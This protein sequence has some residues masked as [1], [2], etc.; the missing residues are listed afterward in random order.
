[1][2]QALRPP[3][4]NIKPRHQP[5]LYGEYSPIALEVVQ[6]LKTKDLHKSLEHCRDAN[7]NER[8]AGLCNLLIYMRRGDTSLTENDVILIRNTLKRFFHEH[9][10]KLYRV[11]IEVLHDFIQLK[12]AYLEGWIETVVRRLLGRLGSELLA[13]LQS[14]IKGTLSSLQ[15]C[16][17]PGF[18]FR[19]TARIIS[20]DDGFEPKSKLAALDYFSELLPLLHPE[21]FFDHIDLQNCLFI[22][23]TDL[24]TKNTSMRLKIQDLLYVLFDLNPTTFNKFIT[25]MPSKLEANLTR[26][27][28]RHW[29]KVIENENLSP[30]NTFHTPP[31]EDLRGCVQN[32]KNLR[33]NINLSEILYFPSDSE[34]TSSDEQLSKSFS[35]SSSSK[36]PTDS[37]LTHSLNLYSI[38]QTNEIET[39]PSGF[40]LLQ[41]PP[42]CTPP[43]VTTS[44]PPPP[45]PL[46]DPP[47]LTY[48]SNFDSVSESI[49]ISQNL[50]DSL[51]Y[52]ILP[53]NLDGS[54]NSLSISQTMELSGLTK[55]LRPRSRIPVSINQSPRLSY[56][57][58]SRFSS[59][60]RSLNSSPLDNIK[61][62]LYY[63]P[64]FVKNN[65]S[66]S[67]RP[68]SSYCGSNLISSVLP[69]SRIPRYKSSPSNTLSTPGVYYSNSQMHNKSS[70]RPKEV[71]YETEVMESSRIKLATTPNKVQRRSKVCL[72]FSMERDSS[73][74]SP[75]N[76]VNFG[77]IQSAKIVPKFYENPE[78]N[79][80]SEQ[81]YSNY[82][83]NNNSSSTF[84]D[85]S[86]SNLQST[87][88]PV[89]IPP[90][91]N[92]SCHDIQTVSCTSLEYSEGELHSPAS[93]SL[94][95]LLNSF[96]S[97]QGVEERTNSMN[98]LRENLK[99]YNFVPISTNV[100]L[101]FIPLSTAVRELISF[102]A[103]FTDKA[104][105]SIHTI[106][107]ISQLFPS[108]VVKET[109]PVTKLLIIS[110]GNSSHTTR[111]KLEDLFIILSQSLDISLMLTILTGHLSN[112]TI[113]YLTPLKLLC[114]LIPHTPPHVL[115][116]QVPHFAPDLV[117]AYQQRLG[118]QNA[119]LPCLVGLYN[120]LGSQ[121]DSYLTELSP[122][123]EKLLMMYV[124]SSAKKRE[125]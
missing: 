75:N 97:A 59:K 31:H 55:S 49:P 96:L 101:L 125:F 109:E 32:D 34:E 54:M 94:E 120:S 41:P 39:S 84:I 88:L 33:D 37:K 38:N 36:E 80:S 4:P 65:I 51:S 105:V 22:L 44:P 69:P 64:L 67:N 83:E 91:T 78:L 63:S 2:A 62:R 99:S 47:S 112:V 70:E 116:L 72:D 21:D 45:I 108:I 23:A 11:F 6:K 107:L 90:V 77:I 12:C 10:S 43:P 29:A 53:N 89:I 87:S 8:R 13:S 85:S 42:S 79:L 26:S 27:I 1:M 92:H 95:V 9:N 18:L 122:S 20:R 86:P 106:Y 82:H 56:S 15:Q 81:E 46:S 104:L 102:S 66:I 3:S 111:N 118:I 119:A 114:K 61:D 124:K 48:T 103:Q 24:N 25:R 68:Y 35:L 123:E 16:Y 71:T 19:I 117:S 73:I 50:Q 60:H 74:I 115:T 93:Q 52:P 30:R 113:N 40:P 57:E 121:L 5:V 98:E 17:V 14:L 76:S 28:R 100:Q 110:H 7:L 58:I